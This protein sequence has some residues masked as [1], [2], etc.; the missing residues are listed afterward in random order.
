MKL[1]WN[2]D[3][4]RAGWQPQFW[5]EGT[6]FI[7]TT[8]ETLINISKSAKEHCPFYFNFKNPDVA[9]VCRAHKFSLKYNFS[10][11]CISVLYL[12]WTRTKQP[13]HC[14]FNLISSGYSPDYNRLDRESGIEISISM[15]LIALDLSLRWN[16]GRSAGNGARVEAN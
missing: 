3:E 10:N 1:R 5:P 16:G 7:F 15:F 4:T 9:K 14:T 2:R 6:S 13:L 12:F 8:F 11:M